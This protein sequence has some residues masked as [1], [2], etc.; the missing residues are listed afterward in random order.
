MRVQASTHTFDTDYNFTT[1][2]LNLSLFKVVGLYP[3][4]TEFMIVDD[5]INY[6]INLNINK[7]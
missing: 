2:F 1:E 6:D 4:L 5:D 7:L 3:N